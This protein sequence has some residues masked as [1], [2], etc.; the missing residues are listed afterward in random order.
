MKI[1][2]KLTAYKE[3]EARQSIIGFGILKAMDYDKYKHGHLVIF[4]LSMKS[5]LFLKKIFIPL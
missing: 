5:V 3:E 4:S 1:F 2:K